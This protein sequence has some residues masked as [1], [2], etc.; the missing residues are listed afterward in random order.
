MRR[1][2]GF[3]AP[4]IELVLGRSLLVLVQ[5]LGGVAAPLSRYMQELSET[6]TG[7]GQR[8][9]VVMWYSTGATA[10][11]SATQCEIKTLREKGAEDWSR[12]WGLKLYYGRPRRRTRDKDEPH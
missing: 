6:E 7:Y 1:S 8:R 3:G 5:C 10:S 11:T 9:D 4:V 2:P 12:Q